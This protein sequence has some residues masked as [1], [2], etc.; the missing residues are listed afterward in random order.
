MNNKQLKELTKIAHFMESV[1]YET[2]NCVRDFN[3][4][5]QQQVNKTTFLEFA[6]MFFERKTW[7]IVETLEFDTNEFILL[8]EVNETLD[9]VMKETESVYQYSVTDENGEHYHTT[10]RKGHIIGILEWALN[11]IVGNIDIEQTI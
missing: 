8:N 7:E 6:L 3:I 10:D 5:T 2:D 4:L 9:S 1:I 11:Q